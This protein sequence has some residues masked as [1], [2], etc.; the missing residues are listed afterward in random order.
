[1][2]KHFIVV[3]LLACLCAADDLYQGDI[4]L[5]KEQQDILQ[6]K[7]GGNA[8]N[9]IKTS[10]WPLTIPYDLAPEIASEPK[11]VEAIQDAIVE[12]EKYTCLKFKKRDDEAGYILF[13]NMDAK[14]CWSPLGYVSTYRRV[15]SLHKYCWYRGTVLHHLMHTLG[16]AHENNRPDRDSF[17]KIL[18]DNIRD[19]NHKDFY[20]KDPF[21]VNSMNV[22]Y[23]YDS[24]THMYRWYLG[25]RT[26]TGNIMATIEALD[27]K[28]KYSIGQRSHL[29]ES[30]ILQLNLLYRCPGFTRPPNT[31]PPAPAITT[32]ATPKPV[33][34]TENICA[35]RT[36]TFSCP[37][38]TKMWIDS[39]MYGRL[40][41]K[42]CGY[43][44]LRNMSCHSDVTEIVRG[45]CQ[46]NMVCKLQVTTEVYGDPCPGTFKYLQIK[47]RCTTKVIAC[48]LNVK[49]IKCPVGQLI[50]VADAMYGR[51]SIYVCPTIWDRETNCK[52]DSSLSVVRA[53]CHMKNS[54]KITARTDAFGDP[55]PGVR[56][57]LQVRYQ[58]VMPN[59][60]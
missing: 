27:R 38:G 11:A 51:Q 23:D 52:S 49:E 1:M 21:S 56:K 40:T 48:N 37:Y 54:C 59:V 43:G 29:S 32:P 22:P 34:Q 35:L 45:K 33:V 60:L 58:C 55:C 4:K 31:L 7:D 14:R 15:I 18:W 39:A 3:L 8:F 30:D 20:R 17:V 41:T 57:Y 6:G 9:V 28:K 44:S 25:K 36:K 53:N 50:Y 12:M 24:I 47:Y 5:T 26:P 42:I 10:I 13:A 2:Y 46:N 19:E 16:F